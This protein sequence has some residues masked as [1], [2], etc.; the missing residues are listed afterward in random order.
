VRAVS[1]QVPEKRPPSLRVIP[2]VTER[3]AKVVF[4]GPV[5]SLFIGL[6]C[7]GYLLLAAKSIR[8]EAH[9]RN[10]CR[11]AEHKRN[12]MRWGP[13]DELVSLAH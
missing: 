12:K 11:N 6:P 8:A 9:V 5:V 3:D 10:A 4:F 1:I 13:E 7:A 2:D